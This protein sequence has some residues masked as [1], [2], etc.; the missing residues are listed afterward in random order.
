MYLTL[1]TIKNIVFY[2]MQIEFELILGSLQSFQDNWL[3]MARL[4]LTKVE[5]LAIDEEQLTEVEQVMALKVLDQK[6]RPPGAQAKSF[7]LLKCYEV[8][9]IIIL[10]KLTCS[11][12]LTC[13]SLIIILVVVSAP[14]RYIKCIT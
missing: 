8:S 1:T 7:P 3:K 4:I 14:V 9:F 12:T 5:G 10:H 13:I 6:V 11:K 2:Q